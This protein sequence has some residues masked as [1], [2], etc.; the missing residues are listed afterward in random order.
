MEEYLPLI[1]QLVSGAIGG[2]VAGSL[3]K[4]FSL[5]TLGNSILG[6]LGGGLGGQLMEMLGLGGAEAAE[7]ATSMDLSSILA[8]VA[9][10]GIGG[11]VLMA[12]VGV[13]KKAMSK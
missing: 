13:I 2:N 3:M 5:G 1:I 6:I 9:G 11:G 12:I 4:K 8:S 10:G 7:A